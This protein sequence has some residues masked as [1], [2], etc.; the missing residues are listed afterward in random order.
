M[1]LEHD[2]ADS[3]RTSLARLRELG[4]LWPRAPSASALPAS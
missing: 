3:V 1:M 2:S 4:L